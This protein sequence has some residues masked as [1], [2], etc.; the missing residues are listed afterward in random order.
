M[1]MILLSINKII[2]D[3]LAGVEHG[4]IATPFEH[5]FI[6]HKVSPIRSH[7]RL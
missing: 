7:F 3:I 4:H 2:L 5:S 6:V 1:S